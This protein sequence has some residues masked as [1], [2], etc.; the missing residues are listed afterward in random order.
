MGLKR[1]I[2]VGAFALAVAT[3]AQAQLGVAWATFQNST[4]T[5]LDPTVTGISSI[6]DEVKFAW[7]DLDKNGWADLVVARKQPFTTPGKRTSVL[8]M[9][10]NGVLTNKTALYAQA[11]DVAG[12]IDLVIGNMQGMWVWTNLLSQGLVC[13]TS[14]GFKSPGS[15]ANLSVCGGDLELGN[16]A[17]MTLT[18]AHALQPAFLFAS[19]SS[20]PVF[21][22]PIGQTLAAFPVAVM[23]GLGTAPNGNTVLTV[24]GTSTTVP[25]DVYVQ[26]VIQKSDG[27]YETSNAVRMAIPIN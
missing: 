7:G 15:S 25:V 16:P 14:I 13:Q 12:D 5:N 1:W 9:N 24:P 17:V 10:Y 20:A 8:L 6:T 2:T 11:A 4:A 3:A 22:P 23:L 19:L 21:V 18:T 27:T 26:F